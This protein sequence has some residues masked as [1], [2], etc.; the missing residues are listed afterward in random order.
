MC[1][2][3]EQEIWFFS[4]ITHSLT[5]TGTVG[6][7]MTLLSSKP[8]TNTGGLIIHFFGCV[9]K[10]KLFKAS[11]FLLGT[12]ALHL[13]NVVF[14]PL[15]EKINCIFFFLRQ[16]EYNRNILFTLWKD[17]VLISW[18]GLE[19]VGKQCLNCV[20]SKHCEIQLW[21]KVF[22]AL[23]SFDSLPKSTNT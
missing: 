13:S 7:L 12:G 18:V 23:Q 1:W 21:R 17:D 11:S 9:L 19:E 14:L 4:V 6:F 8:F 10:R 3:A 20:Y 16:K 15:R 5:L 2:F 22:V